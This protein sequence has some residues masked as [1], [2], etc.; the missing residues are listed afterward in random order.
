VS[1]GR[2]VPPGHEPVPGE[3]R[4]P[5]LP[6]GVETDAWTAATVFGGLV[7]VMATATVCLLVLHWAGVL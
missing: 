3:P 6:E 5:T 7:V 4:D 1:G 2:W